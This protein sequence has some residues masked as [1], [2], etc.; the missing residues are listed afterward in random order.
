MQDEHNELGDIILNRSE[1]SHS[2]KKVLVGIGALLSVLIV[3]VI[4][5]GRF[6]DGKPVAMPALPPAASS[7]SSSSEDDDID[8]QLA[9]VAQ[10]HVP[11]AS[12]S[13]RTAAVAAKTKPVVVDA[14]KNEVVMID[15]PKHTAPHKVVTPKA[16]AAAEPLH[17]AGA[18][19]HSA[20]A[21]PEASAAK[22]GDVYIQVGSFSRYKPAKGFLERIEKSGYAYR[23]HRVVIR[24]EIKN[25]VLVGPFK[26]RA[27]AKA[28]LTDV[29]K[30][31]ESGAFIYTIKEK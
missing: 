29:R 4:A 18:H 26:N 20:P 23:F 28:H 16:A 30:K 10:K 27:D 24:G 7:A 13:A 14:D 6:S 19:H 15:E 9:I 3:I 25:K 12:S 5:M 2:R 11:A 8:R 21:K 31:I 17:V 1:K 22:N